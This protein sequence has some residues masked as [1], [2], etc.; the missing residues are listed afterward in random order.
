MQNLKGGPVLL[1]DAHNSRQL[2]FH[3]YFPIPCAPASYLQ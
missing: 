3:P 2:L 1:P